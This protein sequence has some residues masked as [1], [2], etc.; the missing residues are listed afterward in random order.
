MC[1]PHDWAWAAS[2]APELTFVC[3]PPLSA[4]HSVD[5]TGSRS[6]WP[7]MSSPPEQSF[8][9]WHRTLSFHLHRS[10]FCPF[11]FNDFGALFGLY[12]RPLKNLFLHRD[13]GLFWFVRA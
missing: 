1:T 13:W 8:F 6:H 4:R 12:L 7:P 10:C 3:C 11:F 9:G 5:W 2:S